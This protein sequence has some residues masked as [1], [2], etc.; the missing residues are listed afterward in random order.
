MKSKQKDVIEDD[1][2]DDDLNLNYCINN[3][4]MLGM[5]IRKLW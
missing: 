1:D 2:E 4:C 5:I 3:A